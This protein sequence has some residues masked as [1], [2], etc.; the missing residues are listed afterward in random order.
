MAEERSVQDHKPGD[1]ADT[2]WKRYLEEPVRFL[3]G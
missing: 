3:Q 2:C 1:F